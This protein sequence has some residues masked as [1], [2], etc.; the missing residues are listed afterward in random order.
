MRIPAIF[1]YPFLVW[2][3]LCAGL[4][5]LEFTSFLNPQTCPKDGSAELIDAVIDGD[6]GR[7]VVLLERGVSPMLALAA[8]YSNMPIAQL[9]LE[10][11]A[12]VDGVC[13]SGY[14]G[15]PLFFALEGFSPELDECSPIKKL[16]MVRFLLE[17]GADIHFTNEWGE[18]PLVWYLMKRAGREAE[19]LA[20]E[21]VDLLL[22]YGVNVNAESSR[23][24]SALHYSV[25]RR[26]YSVSGLLLEHGADVNAENLKGS[27]A[28]HISD[29]R[30]SQLLLEYGADVHVLNQDGETPLFNAAY[31]GV[32]QL[33]LLVEN[34]ASLDVVNASGMTPLMKIVR[35]INIPSKRSLGEE[36]AWLFPRVEALLKLGAD[37]NF[38]EETTGETVLFKVVGS[39]YSYYSMD[40]R[41]KAAML[42]FEYGADANAVSHSGRTPLFEV[43]KYEEVY[44]EGFEFVELLLD[45]GAK[46]DVVDLRGETLLFQVARTHWCG[47]EG[48]WDSWSCR[49]KADERRWCAYQVV[50]FF[51]ELGADVNAVSENGDTAFSIAVGSG[52]YQTASL[53]LSHA[54]W[55]DLIQSYDKI[56]LIQLWFYT[57]P[58]WGSSNFSIATNN[59]C[60]VIGLLCLLLEV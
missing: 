19:G 15:S 47:C 14:G 54:P 20:L 4:F 2:F 45:H 44:N 46:A 40:A 56:A 8:L 16:E 52:N 41:I 38:S 25:D 49:G 34:G 11:G 39:E 42:F 23:D 6:E 48:Y 7:V 5:A 50:G 60:G 55:S 17:S 36:E 22:A 18:T 10:H 57:R 59:V 32:D 27:T 3:S 35:G 13:P 12:S 43:F 58:F 33:L 26:C 29:Y 21:I 53:L 37:V 9:F 30:I 51:L 31:E 1:V 28:L 24:F